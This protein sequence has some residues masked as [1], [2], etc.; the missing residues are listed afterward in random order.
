MASTNS[1]AAFIALLPKYPRQ[2][3]TIVA[4]EGE[5]ARLVLPGGG[6]LTA[7]GS[8]EVGDQVFVRDGVIEAKAPDMPFVQV[9]I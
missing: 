4:I 7:L 1:Y 5:V 2:V 9:E 8:G 3:A 6:L